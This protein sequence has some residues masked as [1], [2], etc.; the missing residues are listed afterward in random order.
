MNVM[1]K[2]LFAASLLTATATAVSAAPIL[3]PDEKPAV[4]KYTNYEKVLQGTNSGNNPLAIDAGDK[5]VGILKVTSIDN[6][7]SSDQTFP[8]SKYELTGAFQLS[9]TSGSIPIGSSLGGH[10]D[11]GMSTGDYFQMFY[12][13]AKNFNAQASNSTALATDGNLWLEILPGTTYNGYGDKTTGDSSVYNKNWA[14][15]TTNNTGYTIVKQLWPLAIGQVSP[16]SQYTDVYFESKVNDLLAANTY[17]EGW[18]FLSQD[19]LYITAVPEPST[20]LMLSA[21]LLGLTIAARRRKNQA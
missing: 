19:P 13:S 6:L 14:N 7:F 17:Q 4:I 10:V 12:D 16:A 20:V 9:V 8:I 21:G 3:L 1:K 2:L 11:F 5:I 18:K 15:I